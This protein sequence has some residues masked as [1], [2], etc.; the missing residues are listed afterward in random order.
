M[1]RAINC[2]AVVHLLATVIAGCSP[3]N[4]MQ[5]VSFEGAVVTRLPADTRIVFVDTS[6]SDRV[7]L[8]F[9]KCEISIDPTVLSENDW[10]VMFTSASSGYLFSIYVARELFRDEVASKCVITLGDPAVS[11]ERVGNSV[12]LVEALGKF[13]TYLDLPRVD[14][15]SG[16]LAGPVPPALSVYASEKLDGDSL[17]TGPMVEGCMGSRWYSASADLL[18]PFLDTHCTFV[19]THDS[20]G[21][22]Q[23]IRVVKK[24]HDEE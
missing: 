6:A 17:Y 1:T 13:V 21:L 4:P 12:H 19:I 9:N 15:K 14:S 20:G 2:V 11:V 16:T 18:R 10:R 5:L 8:S 22:L 24:F 23:P 7:A 3:S